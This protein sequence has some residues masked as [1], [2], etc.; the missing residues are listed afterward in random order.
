M[1]AQIAHTSQNANAHRCAC[2]AMQVVVLLC[3]LAGAALGIYLWSQMGGDDLVQ[4]LVA[5]IS[6]GIIVTVF[7][8]LQATAVLLRPRP[9]S[10]LRCKPDQCLVCP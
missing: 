4:L 3:V 5:H 7:V 1:Q 10:K 2:A 6:I 9:D 8:L